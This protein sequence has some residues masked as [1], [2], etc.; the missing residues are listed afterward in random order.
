[1]SQIWNS[2]HEN[3]NPVKKKINCTVLSGDG[4]SRERREENQREQLLKNE[5]LQHLIHRSDNVQII[6]P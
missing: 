2:A 6:L 1:M 5:I 4:L 3:E